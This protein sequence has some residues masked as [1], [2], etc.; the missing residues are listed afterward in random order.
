MHYV[1]YD[2]EGK[3]HGILGGTADM[4]T[5]EWLAANTPEGMTIKAVKQEEAAEAMGW[6][7]ET[8]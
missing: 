5:P 4:A 2:S 1:I 3:V 8:K 7:R 6:A